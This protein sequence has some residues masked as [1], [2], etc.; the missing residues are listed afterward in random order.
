[1]ESGL[2]PTGLLFGTPTD[3]SNKKLKAFT[4]LWTA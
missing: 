4:Y 1:M 3:K 2:Q